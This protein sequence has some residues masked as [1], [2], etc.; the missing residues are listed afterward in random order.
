[1]SDTFIRLLPG[2]DSAFG[3]GPSDMTP[4][5]AFTTEDHSELNRTLTLQTMMRAF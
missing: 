1:M 4:A 3:M 2:G 5:A